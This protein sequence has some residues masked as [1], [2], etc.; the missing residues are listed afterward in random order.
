MGFTGLY[1]VKSSFTE[2]YLISVSWVLLDFYWVL[3]GFI[4]CMRFKVNRTRFCGRVLVMVR[5]SFSDDCYFSVYLK[6]AV[7]VIF[8]WL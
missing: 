8:S 5:S 7:K 3:L 6:L 2:Y 4:A 1:R